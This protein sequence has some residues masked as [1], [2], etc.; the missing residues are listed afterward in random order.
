MRYRININ[1]ANAM[2]AAARRALAKHED[3]LLRDNCIFSDA[4]REA[5][6]WYKATVTKAETRVRRTKGGPLE[7]MPTPVRIREII[8]LHDAGRAIPR[9]WVEINDDDLQ[10]VPVAPPRVRVRP[11][12]HDIGL[13]GRVRPRPAKRQ[14]SGEYNRYSRDGFTQPMVTAA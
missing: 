4:V 7:W 2:P 14:R 1:P 6:G 11:G 9:A 12:R 3:A 5:T 10:L 13:D 8:E